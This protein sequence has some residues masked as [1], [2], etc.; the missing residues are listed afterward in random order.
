M[1]F[2]RILIIILYTTT[3]SAGSGGAP[4]P[5]LAC[6][7]AN[8]SIKS[9]Q[10]CLDCYREHQKNDT[11]INICGR[12]CYNQ[13]GGGIDGA[14]VI[15]ACDSNCTD[16]NV[17]QR[18]CLDYHASKENFEAVTILCGEN[19]VNAR[20]CYMNCHILEETQPPQC[21]TKRNKM[22]SS[23]GK[24]T[25]I[26]YQARDNHVIGDNN[27]LIVPTPPC[28]AYF[29]DPITGNQVCADCHTGKFSKINAVAFCGPVR[30]SPCNVTDPSD[31]A[32]IA[33]CKTCYDNGGN[34]NSCGGPNLGFQGPALCKTPLDSSTKI[35]ACQNCH[36]AGGNDKSCGGPPPP[37]AYMPPFKNNTKEMTC[38]GYYHNGQNHNICGELKC[39]S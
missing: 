8:D 9:P 17:R 28:L 24:D 6:S 33:K 11:T 14:S 23:C 31:T 3:L 38:N 10:T 26:C 20:I 1:F 15:R 35:Q 32:G 2:V 16:P 30:K 19:D 39:I 29:D 27:F 21:G 22:I 18:R 34:F 25:Y 12:A 37:L 5:E 7:L 13:T 36:K 4:P